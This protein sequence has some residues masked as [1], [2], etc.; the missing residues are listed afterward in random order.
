MLSQIAWFDE[1]IQE[2]DEAVRG[3]IAKGR[4]FTLED[5]SLMGRKQVEI[6]GMV[7]PE[8]KKLAATGQIE[9][10]TT[11]FY[12]PILPLLCDSDIAAVSHPGVPLPHRFSYPQDAHEQLHRARTYIEHTFGVAPTGLWPSEGS[13]SDQVFEIASDLGFKWAATDNGVLDR[14]LGQGAGLD[15]MYR[16]WRWEQ[17]G[18]SMGVIFRDHMLSDLVGFVYSGMGDADAANDLAAP[19]PRQLL[20]HPQPTTRRPGPHHPGWRKRLGVLRA[21][22]ATV[23]P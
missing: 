1:E 3:L 2:H 18:R 17:R 20:Q 14:T 9:I 4:D 23:L 19:H 13:V 21:Q 15:G 6:I 11:P 16:T 10:S 22:W 7:I 5:Q 8:Y 12:H